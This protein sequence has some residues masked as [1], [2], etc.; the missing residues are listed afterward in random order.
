METFEIRLRCPETLHDEIHAHKPEY[1]PLTGFVM[2]L[3]EE[4]LTKFMTRNKLPACRAGAAGATT[5]TNEVGFTSS[6]TTTPPQS[7]LALSGDE[8]ASPL[9]Q[10]SLVEGEFL[11]G[12]PL[13][14]GDSKGGEKDPFRFKKLDPDVIPCDL[15]DCQQLL[16]EFWSVKKGVRSEQVFNRICNKLRP[17]S[18]EQRRQALESAINNGWGDVFEPRPQ[19]QHE[20]GRKSLDQLAAE[21][22]AMPRLW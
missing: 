6:I 17:W 22:D 1:L 16:P 15:L 7:S 13:N 8:E 5:S 18:P 12:Q 21:M 9:N 20:T 19:R 4:G 10:G 3:I 2:L 11:K 14:R